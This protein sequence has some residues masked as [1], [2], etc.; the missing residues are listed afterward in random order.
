MCLEETNHMFF[1]KKKSFGSFYWIARKDDNCFNTN[2]VW[3]FV[4]D[5]DDV[6][7]D[8]GADVVDAVTTI[9][10]RSERVKR[11]L[12]AY[13]CFCCNFAV[14]FKRYNTMKNKHND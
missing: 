7:D 5:V 9:L 13:L 1:K 14:M 6:D 8:D 12:S 11:F 2:F 3:F 4:V 10:F